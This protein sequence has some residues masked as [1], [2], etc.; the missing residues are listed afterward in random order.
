MGVWVLDN[1][2]GFGEFSGGL[3]VEIC[4]ICSFLLR[5]V[6]KGEC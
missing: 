4:G 6:C 3:S 5:V 2:W 1:N